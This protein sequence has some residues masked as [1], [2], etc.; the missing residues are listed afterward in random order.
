M[1]QGRR[2]AVGIHEIDP[3]AG[4]GIRLVGV[5]DRNPLVA[6]GGPMSS[7]ILPLKLIPMG[8]HWMLVSSGPRGVPPTVALLSDGYNVQSEWR[9]EGDDIAEHGPGMRLAGEDCRIVGIDGDP[10]VEGAGFVGP[11]EGKPRCG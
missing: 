9:V 10:A 6:Q 1:N 4:I 5:P 3:R 2:D 11:G 8:D 7:G